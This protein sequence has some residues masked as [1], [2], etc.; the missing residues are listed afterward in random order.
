MIEIGFEEKIFT[1]LHDMFRDAGL[2]VQAAEE[3]RDK[4]QRIYESK[5]VSISYRVTVSSMWGN[6][7]EEAVRASS[8]D[9]KRAIRAAGKKHHKVNKR[10]DWQVYWNVHV[11][12]AAGDE[13]TSYILHPS[14]FK[15]FLPGGQVEITL[16]L[17]TK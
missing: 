15:E 14:M 6:E 9:I 17:R 13:K 7:G 2:A 5:D 8:K 12:F 11:I 4:L 10:S 3:R 16:R 1:G